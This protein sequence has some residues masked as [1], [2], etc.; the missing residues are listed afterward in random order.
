MS[1][2]KS[3]A[4][5]LKSRCRVIREVKKASPIPRLLYISLLVLFLVDFFFYPTLLKDA[6][7][8]DL[9]KNLLYNDGV[10]SN[11]IVL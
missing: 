7:K 5:A 6:S 11:L 1:L 10:A 2:R 3:L 8:K 4:F 9:L